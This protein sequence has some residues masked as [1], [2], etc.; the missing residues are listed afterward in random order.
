VASILITAAGAAVLAVSLWV[1]IETTV[2]YNR[3]RQPSYFVGTNDAYIPDV[4]CWSALFI[5]GIW[6]LVGLMGLCCGGQAFG[7]GYHDNETY[8]Y[9]SRY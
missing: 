2:E 7:K 9:G 8:G 3:T 1:I 5:G 6:L 4:A